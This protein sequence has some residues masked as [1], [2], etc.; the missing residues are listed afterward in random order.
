MGITLWINFNPQ[1]AGPGIILYL[2]RRMDSTTIGL[3]IIA[4]TINPSLSRGGKQNPL[5]CSRLPM[6]ALIPM[7][8]ITPLLQ[9]CD[10]RQRQLHLY[11][12]VCS[13]ATRAIVDGDDLQIFEDLGI[14]LLRP[15]TNAG[16]PG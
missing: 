6:V 7:M 13:P 15:V 10:A 11:A 16:F 3:S 12:P 2:V 1:M 14:A 5:A 9:P 8:E 4:R